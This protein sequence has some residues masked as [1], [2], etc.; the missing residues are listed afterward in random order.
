MRT[1]LQGN[2]QFS[3]G[4]ANCPVINYCPQISAVADLHAIYTAWCS[5]DCCS[6]LSSGDMWQRNKMKSSSIR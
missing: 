1:V 3:N 6:L 5:M 2:K 4:L